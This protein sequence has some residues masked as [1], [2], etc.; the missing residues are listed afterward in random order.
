MDSEKLGKFIAG[1]RREKGMTQAEL[2]QKLQVTDKAVS[3]W[4]RGIGLPDINLIE[5][6]AEALGVSVVEIMKSQRLEEN[7]MKVDEAATVV[8][9]VILTAEAQRRKERRQM[10]SAAISAVAG[11]LV[12]LLWDSL[13]IMGMAGVALP[14]MCMAAAISLLIYGII[15]RSRKAFIFAGLAAAVVVVFVLLLF[16]AGILGLGPVPE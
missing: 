5:P 9:E 12:F 4:E 13:G 16:L 10:I 2:A 1:L 3:R 11:V 8:S 7:E 14:C 6:L 15:R